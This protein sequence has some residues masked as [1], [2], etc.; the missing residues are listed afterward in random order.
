VFFHR[1]VG[2]E[3]LAASIQAAEYRLGPQ[4]KETIIEHFD[5]FF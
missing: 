5:N 4:K 2:V 1:S 3:E